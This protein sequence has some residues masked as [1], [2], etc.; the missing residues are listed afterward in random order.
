MNT[1]LIGILF[2]RFDKPHERLFLEREYAAVKGRRSVVL[3][4]LYCIVLFSL[5][6]VVVGRAGLDGLRVKMEDPFTSLLSITAGSMEYSNKY[7]EIRDLLDS[8]ATH[9]RFNAALSSGNYYSGWDFHTRT[10]ERPYYA[11]VESFGFWKDRALLGKILGAENLLHNVSGGDLWTADVYRNGII[12]DRDL[13]ETI[14][15]SEEELREKD[16]VIVEGSYVFPLRVVAVVH[17]LPNRCRVYAEHTLVKSIKDPTANNVLVPFETDEAL[18]LLNHEGPLGELEQELV[19]VFATAFEE[20]VEVEL[21]PSSRWATHA[22]EAMVKRL[23]GKWRRDDLVYY[24]EKLDTLEGRRLRNLQPGVLLDLRYR[25]LNEERV[26]GNGRPN[27]GDGFDHLTITF[28]N[29]DSIGHFQEHLLDALGVELDLQRVESQKNFGTVSR[30]SLFLIASLVM[31]ALL[32]I[33]LFLYDL[34]KS[35]LERIKMNLGTFMAFGLSEEFLMAGYLRI[36]FRLLA[37]VVVL[38]LL[39]LLL[40]Q[41]VL[42]GLGAVGWSVSDM[43]EHVKVLDNGWLYLSLVALFISSLV[44]CSLQL[45]RFL[46]RT[47]GDLIYART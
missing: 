36:L 8:C 28:S 4:V 40:M 37:T 11:A 47:P 32:A 7:D 22:Y 24:Q 26:F 43:A 35:H 18:V 20:P 2:R 33:L 13:F 15:C 12:I 45:R 31:F 46:S 14:G 23:D 41:A 6:A 27:S 44:I 39:T 5:T 17:S 16:V 30:L 9:A 21:R 29:L 3:L 25:M 10:K 19:D 38:V 1:G 34:L 42:L